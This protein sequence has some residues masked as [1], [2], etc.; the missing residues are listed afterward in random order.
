[1]TMR[2]KFTSTI[3]GASIFITAVLLLGRGL[4]LI[5]EVI[6]ANYF[7]LSAEY[8][9]YLV[10]TVLPITINTIVLYIAQNYFIPNYSTAKKKS[11]GE[12]ISF[13]G[14]TV[15]FFL[16]GG[17]IISLILFVLSDKIFSVYLPDASAKSLESTIGLF[18]IVL[19]AIPIFSVS[20]VFSAYLQA[21]FEFR[22]PSL[23][24]LLLNIALI[25]LVLAFHSSI[26]VKAIAI[27]YVAG[28]I[29]QLLLLLYFVQKEIN[30]FQFKFFTKKKYLQF[31][32]GSLILIIVI[33][34]I[35]QLFMFSDR[36]FYKSVE[37]GGIAALNYAIHLY[38][39]PLSIISMAISTAIFPS[40]SKSIYAE[41]G[42]TEKHL[43]NFFSINTLLFI[44]ITIVIIYFGDTIIRVLFERGEFTTHDSEM[45]Y[46]A[47][48]IYA[49]SLIFFS[50]YTVLNKLI[51][52]KKLIGYLLLVAVISISLKILLN[53][54]FVVELK[55]NGLALSTTL[56]YLSFFVLSFFVVILKVKL[57][58]KS[59]FLRELLWGLVNGG[60]SILLSSWLTLLLFHDSSIASDI[61]QI[62]IFLLFYGLNSIISGHHSVTL[63][64]NAL[65]TYKH[66]RKSQVEV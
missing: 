33:E 29:L 60:A 46:S 64:T 23:S 31:I 47:L 40:L 55:Q 56:S 10:A 14:F 5:R 65:L 66:Y 7:G 42:E 63:L 2:P 34:S 3:A 28:A 39:L 61:F 57:Y 51:Y 32:S 20:S 48:K 13:T 22:L 19:L 16:F 17:I 21:R 12:A 25:I 62:V 11:E 35:S 44:P 15:W 38:L 36:Y 53:F 26:G 4:G 8:D 1:M 24:Q 27:G 30:L 45:T 52:S 41:T 6:F 49:F 59:Y 58:D 9:L 54:I 50:S 37:A 43:N 18:K